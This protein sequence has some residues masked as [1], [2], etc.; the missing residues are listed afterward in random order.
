MAR[1][2][3][4]ARRLLFIGLAGALLC[5]GLAS[6][7]WLGAD[8][9]G[10]KECMEAGYGLGVEGGGSLMTEEGCK[11]TVPTTMGTVSGVLPTINESVATA[12]LLA[13]LAGAIPPSI[14]LWL[15][16]KHPR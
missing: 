5:A 1:G 8:V 14:C 15:A 16:T 9:L 12:A 11:L 2:D 13:G 7:L 4:R 10:T 6:L 3:N